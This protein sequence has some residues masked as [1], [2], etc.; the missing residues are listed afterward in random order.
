LIAEGVTTMITKLYLM[1][2]QKC[3]CSCTYC[4]IPHTERDK[5]C[6]YT[7]LENT[8]KQ[9]I[10][11]LTKNEELDCHPEIRFIGGEPYLA[12][13][14]MVKLTNLFLSSIKNSKVII[15]SNGTLI[16]DNF[17]KWLNISRL[18]DVVHILSLDGT[19]EIHNTRRKLKNKKNAFKKTVEAIKLLKANNLPVYLN[20]VLDEYT[21]AGL[22][23]FMH[24]LRND[25][26]I[27]ELSVS[28]LFQPG[29]KTDELAKFQ[30]LKRVYK[31]AAEN[32]LLIGGHHRLLLGAKIPEFMCRAGE[33]TLLLS[34][35]QKI[36]AC[37]RFV[38][39]EEAEIFSS[40]SKFA[41]INCSSCVE[42]SC[43]STENQLLGRKLFNLY[44]NEYSKYLKVNEFD[45]I[46]FGVI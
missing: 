16:V 20:M 22:G 14:S 40:S 3:N 13:E 31:L 33:Q 38:G 37:Q 28:L 1:P 2:T 27:N 32:E 15:N 39:R 41:D 45:K 24:Y 4:Y 12:F 46:L 36:Y 5:S 10:A 9:F 35:D 17:S 42:R 21:I 44:K 6:E 18:Y 43:Y 29:K 8:V 30:L 7:F 19:E 25:L 11:E 23:N 26:N 34:G